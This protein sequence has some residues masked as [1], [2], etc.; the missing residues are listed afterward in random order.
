MNETIITTWIE[1][2][3][4]A[5]RG[6]DG[7]GVDDVFSADATYRTSP[8]D[9]V[10]AGLDAIRTLWHERTEPDESFE[11][12]YEIVA[13]EGDIAVIKLDVEYM[14]PRHQAWKDIWIIQLDNEGLCFAF[15]EWPLKA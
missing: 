11:V 2:Y 8:F 12:R 4:R 5:W 9:D 13:I 10:V 14:E 6:E 1:Q 15:E 7:I 3:I